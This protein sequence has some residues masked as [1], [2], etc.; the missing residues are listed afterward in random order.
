[1]ART[2]SRR[3]TLRDVAERAE[4]SFKT[5]SRVVN[6]EAGV[7]GAVVGRVQT[8][9]ES[10]GYVPDERARHLRQSF[11]PV[12][13]IGFVLVDVSNPFFSAVLRGLED[14]ARA[15]QCLVL[16][17]SSD[18]DASRQD[19]L[20][21]TLLQRRVAGMVVVPC[22]DHLGRLSPEIIQDVPVVYLDCEP[23]QHTN[24]LVRTDHYAGA[25]A[26]AEHLLAQGH[27]DIGFLGDDPSVF[28]AGLR[29]TGYV[30]AMN[31]AGA[32]VRDEWVLTGRH[33]QFAWH[34][35]VRDWLNCLQRRPTAVITAQNFVT[36]GA[37]RALH[38][39]GLAQ[40]MAMVAFDEVDLSDV[41]QPGITV[42]PQE[43]RELG[44]RAGELLFAR[45]DGSTEAPVRELR[46]S[47]LVRRGSGEL[48][49]Q[50]SN[51][52]PARQ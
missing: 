49:V 32:R 24:D 17:A 34:R 28:S 23:S 35:L 26:M 16:S 22:D 43:P 48:P 6:G 41:L 44:R 15:R 3:P 12:S 9:I 40:T 47:N 52:P 50:S 25:R 10:L 39:L 36:I 20:I 14:V 31:D 1:M 19:Q 27:R 30:D 4:V 2:P 33:D 29:F 11:A 37:V 46:L 21:E 13:S 5:V 45:I 18:Q 7:S 51:V 42:L 8:A 38:E